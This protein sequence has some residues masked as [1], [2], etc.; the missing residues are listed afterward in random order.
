MFKVNLNCICCYVLFSDESW[1]HDF[2]VVSL[3]Y[4]KLNLT[5]KCLV[6]RWGNISTCSLCN[7]SKLLVTCLLS[8]LY[9]WYKCGKHIQEKP[10]NCILV[11]VIDNVIPCVIL[12]VL[13]GLAISLHLSVSFTLP[14]LGILNLY[15]VLIC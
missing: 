13:E 9:Y 5:H 10:A 2:L 8:T 7:V 14:R 4:N 11:Y 3:Y 15:Y 12:F 1:P 6:F